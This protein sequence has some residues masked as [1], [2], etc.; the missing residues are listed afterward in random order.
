M[1]GFSG[2]NMQ[3][4]SYNFKILVFKENLTPNK[5]FIAT[6]IHYPPQKHEAAPKD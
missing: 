5:T 2:K 6:L 4:E 3:S 1:H